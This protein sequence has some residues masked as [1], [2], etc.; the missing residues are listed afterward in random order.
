MDTT[1][2]RIRALRKNMGLTQSELAK[3]F[4]VD[5]S[6]VASWEINRRELDFETLKQL[7]VLF[8]VRPDYLLCTTDDR[9]ATTQ[10]SPENKKTKDLDEFLR[11][12]D[13]M[14]KG[15]PLSEDAK[16][17]LRNILTEIDGMAKE[18]NRRKPK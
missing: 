14:F 6:T 15:T 5:R 10:T 2:N 1:G 3:R 18:M 4:G 11:E 17:R 16:E 8:N 13:I 7:S 9:Q 12:A